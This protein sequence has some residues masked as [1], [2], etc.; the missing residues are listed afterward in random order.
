MQL[1]YYCAILMYTIILYPQIRLK[2]PELY[3]L[4]NV[5]FYTVLHCV[6]HFAR[7]VLRDRPPPSITHLPIPHYNLKAFIIKPFNG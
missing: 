1:I 5:Q 7:R 2:K 4:Y 6:L 3:I